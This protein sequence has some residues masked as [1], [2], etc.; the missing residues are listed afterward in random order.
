VS[1]V[2]RGFRLRG[3]C[4]LGVYLAGLARLTFHLPGRR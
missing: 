1:V 2:T 3:G 4:D